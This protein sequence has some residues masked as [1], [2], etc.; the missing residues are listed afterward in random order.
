MASHPQEYTSEE[1]MLSM[2]DIASREEAK[3]NGTAKKV[4][5][6]AIQVPNG[7]QHLFNK[8]KKM[9]PVTKDPSRSMQHVAH[10][11]GSG[12]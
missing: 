10:S 8:T 3:R 4:S 12:S 11:N 9:P 7:Y 2:Q 6:P 1:A 5:L